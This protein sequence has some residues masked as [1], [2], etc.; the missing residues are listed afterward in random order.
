M[1]GPCRAADIAISTKGLNRILQY[2]P[3]DLTVSVEAGFGWGDLQRELALRGQTIALDPPFSHSATVG[4]VVASNSSGPCRARFG[5]SRDLVIGMQFA[6]LEG[7]LV[8]TGGMVVKNVAGLDMGKLMIGSFGTLAVVTSINFR[9]HTLPAA[10]NTFLLAFPD[11]DAVISQRDTILASFL[12]PLA[13]DLLTPPASARL[14]RRG[15]L[16]AIRAG[17][18][19]AVLERYA[20]ELSTSQRLTQND[21]EAFWKLVREFPCDFLRRQGGGVI[22]R[23][24]TPLKE[25][26]A[27]LDLVPGLCISRAASG[28]THI[29]LNG[30]QQIAGVW[31]RFAQRG[32]AAVVEFAPDNVRQ[33]RSLWLA[34]GENRDNAFAMMKNIKQ[35]FDPESL[36]NRSRL[37][38][39][40]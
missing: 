3:N 25:I 22:L 2:E 8:R 38:G 31:D 30:P 12:R 14:G 36:L 35:M 18:S 5:T 26:G 7:R 15:Y 28:V 17:G 32:W 27:L 33:G 19:P 40:I 13:L 10:T 34:P 16:L 37:Y 23:V 1:G 29:Y 4:G 11:L 20:H 9:L 6:T 21:D 24:S 39:R